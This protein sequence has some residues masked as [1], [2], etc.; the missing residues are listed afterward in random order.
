MNA[1]A[2]AFLCAALTAGCARLDATAPTPV[3][4]PD[5][6]AEMNA[7]RK[8]AGLAPVQSIDLPMT[9]DRARGAWSHRN[10]NLAAGHAGFGADVMGANTPGDWAG[11]N[12]YRGPARSNAQEIVETWSASPRHKKIMLHKGAQ[13]CS[14]ASAADDRIAVVALTCAGDP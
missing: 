3:P 11:E 12:L 9:R 13:A 2:F 14:A 5:V 6:V 4:R 1:K 7:L 10:G 8:S